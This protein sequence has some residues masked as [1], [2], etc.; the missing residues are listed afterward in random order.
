MRRPLRRATPHRLRTRGNLLRAVARFNVPEDVTS[1]SA[2]LGHANPAIT[3]TVYS[4]VV[5]R[6]V[7]QATDRIARILGEDSK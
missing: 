4:H 5:S 1:V 3:Y 2:A 7:R 6:K